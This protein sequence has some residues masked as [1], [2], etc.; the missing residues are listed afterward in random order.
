MRV[1]SQYGVRSVAESDRARSCAVRAAPRYPQAWVE[2]Q[3][4]VRHRVV[5]VRRVSAR[6]ADAV[7]RRVFAAAAGPEAC[8]AGAVFPARVAASS[9][10][11]REKRREVLRVV[12][13]RPEGKQWGS[14]FAGAPRIE[15][16]EAPPFGPARAVQQELERASPEVVPEAP[17]E[18]AVSA[19]PWIPVEVAPEPILAAAQQP[20][21][22]LQGRAS[23][24]PSVLPLP[25]VSPRLLARVAVPALPLVLPFPGGRRVQSQQLPS[26]VPSLQLLPRAAR[27]LQQPRCG[28]SFEEYPQAGPPRCWSA[29]S[30]AH[31]CAAA[32]ESLQ[33]CRGSARAR[34]HRLEVFLP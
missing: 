23:A 25:R 11:L 24:V 8:S 29:T 17:E 12:S 33:S 21:A 3:F 32:H 9:S 31:P 15:L 20:A 28:V 1:F 30:R 22:V 19:L 5:V 6:S 18:R 2:E 7:V 13:F 26:V 34:A 16:R 14:R 27:Q 10:A 4:L